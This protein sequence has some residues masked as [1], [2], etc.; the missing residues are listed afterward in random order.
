MLNQYQK[1]KIYDSELQIQYILVSTD[2]KVLDEDF[3]HDAGQLLRE[4]PK[5]Y[6]QLMSP[7][8]LYEFNKKMAINTG[9]NIFTF[10]DRFFSDPLEVTLENLDKYSRL[11]TKAVIRVYIIQ[12]TVINFDCLLRLI[13]NEQFSFFTLIGR[14]VP[15]LDADAQK[16]FFKMEMI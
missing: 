5:D 12:S 8:Q 1:G 6:Q 2:D 3:L 14:P 4:L 9:I 16:I 15:E 13:L 10:P 11:F 7:I